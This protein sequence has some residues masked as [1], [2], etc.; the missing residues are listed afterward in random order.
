MRKPTQVKCTHAEFE[1]QVQRLNGMI[2]VNAVAGEGTGSM[3]SFDFEPRAST[4]RGRASVVDDGS[5]ERNQIGLFVE[6]AAWRLDHRKKAICS[7]T[8]DN[9]NDGKMVTALMGLIGKRVTNARMLNSANDLELIFSD[10]SIF[11][12][13]C[14]QMNEVDDYDNFSL[15]TPQRTYV[16]SCGTKVIA[17]TKE[18]APKRQR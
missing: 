18:T 6:F 11:R 5:G 2:C 7:S 12:V 8:S 13:F 17:F 15:H 10:G 1:S 9:S 14:D 4:G 3:V 16:V